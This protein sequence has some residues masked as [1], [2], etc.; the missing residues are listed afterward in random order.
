MRLDSILMTVVLASAFAGSLS[1]DEVRRLSGERHTGTVQSITPTEVTIGGSVKEVTVPVNEISAV[2]FAL[3]PRGLSEARDAYA[4]GRYTNVF[5]SLSE[6]KP[7]QIR[8]NEMKTEIEFYRTASA[9]R[10]ASVGNVDQKTATAAGMDLNR[11]LTEHKNSYHFYEANEA[12]GDLL[13]ALTNTNAFRYY[14]AIA[15]APW[16]EY[17]I[18]AAVLKGRAAQMH[19]NHTAALDHFDTALR[20]D[21]TGRA[22][23]TQFQLARIG[24][25]TSL[26]ETGKV[27]DA[28]KLL[29]EVVAKADDGDRQIYAHA[30]NA[31]GAC[32]RK[33]NENKDALLAYL[34][35][36]LLFNANPDAHAE[37]L[38]NLSQLW[39]EEHHPER[40]R[41]AVDTLKQR[42]A[43]SRWN[44][45]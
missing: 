31:I 30:Y 37:A 18:R 19:N 5:A 1:A 38:F 44:K 8:R 2:V 20:I 15:S 33:K 42:Y 7:E 25:A 10:M 3:E 36:D 4:S 34:K 39:N 9:A 35:V 11:F 40:A 6:I 22:A 23:E 13:A 26:A 27:D 29:E 45:S 12:L 32:H 24:R 17:K 14:D 28:L 21:G 41:A 43:T 16:P